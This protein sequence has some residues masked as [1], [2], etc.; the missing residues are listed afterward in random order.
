MTGCP[1]C[2]DVFN[3]SEDFKRAAQSLAWVDHDSEGEWT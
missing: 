3:V 1:I 2:P